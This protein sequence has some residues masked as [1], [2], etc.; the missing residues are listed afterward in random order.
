MLLKA[1]GSWIPARLHLMAPR[2]S[3]K[4]IE[5]VVGRDLHLN[6]AQTLF[7]IME[8]HRS[9]VKMSQRRLA[10]KA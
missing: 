8:L 5:A 1:A 7:G 3:A 6:M 4:R 2:L 10:K 9:A